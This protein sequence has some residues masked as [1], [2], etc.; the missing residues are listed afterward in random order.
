MFG[1]VLVH[2]RLLRSDASSAGRAAVSLTDSTGEDTLP[3]F[4]PDGRRLAFV[5]NR[6]GSAEI[7]LLDLDSASTPRPLTRAADGVLD[8]AW[9]AGTGH[10]LA[11]QIEDGHF[12]LVAID[13]ERGGIRELTPDGVVPLQTVPDTD[14]ETLWLLTRAT[15]AQ[16]IW[17]GTRGAGAD[18]DWTTTGERAS[19]IG[20]SRR[21]SGLFASHGARDG[22]QALDADL[23]PIRHN[24]RGL[25]RLGWRPGNRGVWLVVLKQVGQLPLRW[26]GDEDLGPRTI[27][28]FHGVTNSQSPDVAPDGSFVV[29]SAIER[30]DTEIGMIELPR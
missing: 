19:W 14:G 25:L 21:Q 17:R 27:A 26:H 12:R 9:D 6:R 3:E 2:S 1:R 22:V 23:R 28:E 30:N 15:D 8:L 4:A 10:L 5:R 18:Y 24:S 20:T 7:L 11:T 16:I 29:V 13:P